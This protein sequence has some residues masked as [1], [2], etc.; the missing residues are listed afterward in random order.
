MIKERMDKLQR[1]PRER[2]KAD[3]ESM[4]VSELQKQGDTRCS[5]Q[6]NNEQD[7]QPR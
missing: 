7:E 4:K 5:I 1:R 2:W 6:E 3:L